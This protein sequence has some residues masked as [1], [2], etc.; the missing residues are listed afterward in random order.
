MVPL[1]IVVNKYNYSTVLHFLFHL[2]L[3]C[4]VSIITCHVMSLLSAPSSITFFYVVYF[5][6][7]SFVLSLYFWCIASTLFMIL[8]SVTRQTFPNPV[9]LSSILLSCIGLIWTCCLNFSFL[10]L[11]FSEVSFLRHISLLYISQKATMIAFIFYCILFPLCPL[12]YYFLIN[13]NIFPNYRSQI[14]EAPRLLSYFS[15]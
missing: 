8:S 11:F 5:L 2:F 10:I 14:Y 4:I 12:C 15:V 6:T 7:F 3:S 9:N 13:L 1:I